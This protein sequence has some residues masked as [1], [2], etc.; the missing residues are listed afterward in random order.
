MS[1]LANGDQVDGAIDDHLGDTI[2]AILPTAN[3]NFRYFAAGDM[4]RLLKALAEVL[5]VAMPANLM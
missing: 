5:P 4:E 2:I 1:K 3:G